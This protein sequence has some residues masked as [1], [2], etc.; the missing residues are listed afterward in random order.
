MAKRKKRKQ[1]TQV[2]TVKDLL[3]DKEING[4]LNL[5]HKL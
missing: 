5:K 4:L 3:T 1:Y 2:I